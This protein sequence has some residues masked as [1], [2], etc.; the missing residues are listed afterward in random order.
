[1]T[2]NAIR[3]QIIEMIEINVM[4]AAH[5]SGLYVIGLGSSGTV[6]GYPFGHTYMM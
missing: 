3:L 1:V 2:L 6:N 5:V 4:S